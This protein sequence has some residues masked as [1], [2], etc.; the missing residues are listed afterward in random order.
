MRVKT[1]QHS[2]HPT[3]WAQTAGCTPVPQGPCA[4]PKGQALEPRACS[5][6]P[7]PGMA[8]LALGSITYLGVNGV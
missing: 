7:G 5:S 2:P 1:R 8:P 6:S 3:T 4:A